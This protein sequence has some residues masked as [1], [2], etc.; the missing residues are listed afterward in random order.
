M[1]HN[2]AAE[3]TTIMELSHLYAEHYL[4]IPRDKRHLVGLF[5]T[6][7]LLAGHWALDD[8]FGRTYSDFLPTAAKRP[9]GPNGGDV[10]KDFIPGKSCG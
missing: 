4:E 2:L 3:T 9:N 5:A 1:Q 6:A 10:S 7:Q 8:V